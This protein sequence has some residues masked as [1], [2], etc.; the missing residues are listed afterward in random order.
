[1]DETK[2]TDLVSIFTWL[3]S[4]DCFSHL[5]NRQALPVEKFTLINLDPIR[6]IE[7]QMKSIRLIIDDE[8]ILS[9]LLEKA[10][11]QGS[12]TIQ[13]TFYELSKAVYNKRNSI[14]YLK[15]KDS[16]HSLK[17]SIIKLKKGNQGFIFSFIDSLIFENTDNEKGKITIRLS[18]EI[19]NFFYKK[20][21]LLTS[22]DLQIYRTIKGRIQKRLFL[23]FKS[24]NLP[25]PTALE[26]IKEILQMERIRLKDFKKSFNSQLLNA[27]EQS[28]VILEILEGDKISVRQINAKAKKLFLKK[29][30]EEENILIPAG[31]NLKYISSLK[32]IY[33]PADVEKAILKLN[34]LQEQKSEI[35]IKNPTGFLNSILRDRTYLD[36]VDLSEKQQITEEHKKQEIK[37]RKSKEIKEKNN[38][39]ADEYVNSLINKMPENDYENEIKKLVLADKITKNQDLKRSFAILTFKSNLRKKF[40]IN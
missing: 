30:K 34:I 14:T 37:N 9:C 26:K 6:K 24:V 32:N 39:K 10:K 15:I 29:T 23:Y 13:T 38:K 12:S 17:A 8:I 33:P 27:L 2:K 3:N 18:E 16:L 1:M 11:K 7:L 5:M 22:I 20:N 25:K 40:I 19:F 35:N 4:T 31:V 36:V 21:T 28:G